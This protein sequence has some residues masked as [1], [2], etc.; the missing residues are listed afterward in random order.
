L[1][2]R[3]YK[4]FLRNQIY[5]RAFLIIF[6]CKPEKEK[7]WKDANCDLGQDERSLE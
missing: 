4:R 1:Y 7:T 2:M 3:L 6:Y 5:I